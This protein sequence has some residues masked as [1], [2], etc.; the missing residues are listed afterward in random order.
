MGEL[1]NNGWV[2]G[3]GGG[4]LSRLIVAWLTRTIFSKKD[5]REL[6]I[7]ILSANREILYAIRP[8]ISESNLP[9]SEVIAAL[10]N[11]TARK[12]KIEPRHLYGITEIIE[13]IIKEIK[14]SSF[15]SSS[16]KKNTANL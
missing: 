14:D 15:I 10:K 4:V 13:E 9:T 16:V 3:I 7:N 5:L 1:L 6:S 2:V 8:E 12:Y 11:A